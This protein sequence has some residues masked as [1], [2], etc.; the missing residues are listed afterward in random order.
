MTTFSWDPAPDAEVAVAP[1]VLMAEFGDGYQQRAVDGINA[2]RQIWSLTFSRNDE[3]ADDIVAFLATAGG[4]TSFDWT[5][6]KASNS[7]KVI[8]R[9]WR[10]RDYMGGALVQATFEQV[11]ES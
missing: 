3:D 7:I 11:F 9:N 6:P 4:S 8:C 10:R 2:T 1:R 5:P